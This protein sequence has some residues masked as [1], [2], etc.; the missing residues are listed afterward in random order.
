MPVG[1]LSFN[2]SVCPLS[3]A[4]AFA[5]AALDEWVTESEHVGKCVRRQGEPALVSVVAN[6]SAPAVR[7][8]Y[9][10]FVFVFI[11]RLTAKWGRCEQRGL[12]GR[13]VSTD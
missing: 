10:F 9:F 2:F 1:R 6:L 7:Y 5:F 11:L 12:P 3:S 4:F 8:E 13:A